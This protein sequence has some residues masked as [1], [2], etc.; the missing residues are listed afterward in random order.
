MEILTFSRRDSLYKKK[1]ILIS[2]YSYSRTIPACA[3]RLGDVVM[4]EADI[5]PEKK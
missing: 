2:D 1:V 3:R 5:M 4:N